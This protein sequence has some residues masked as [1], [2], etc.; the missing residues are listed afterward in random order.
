[1]SI[2]KNIIGIEQARKILYSQLGVYKIVVVNNKKGKW[3]FP[4]GSIFLFSTG[5][6]RFYLVP[7]D[8]VITLVK[9]G[10]EN[11]YLAKN[12]HISVKQLKK[13]LNIIFQ[14]NHE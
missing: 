9:N 4:Y 12:M 2:E 5:S 13:A 7:K 8:A 11:K 10:I 3:V 6:Q 14:N 1:M